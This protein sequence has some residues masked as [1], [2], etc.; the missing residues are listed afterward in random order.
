MSKVVTL[1]LSEKEYKTISAAAEI[2]HRPISNFITTM[3]LQEIEK[4]YYVDPIEMAQ[5]KSDKRLSEKLKTGHID[6]QKRRGRL[7]G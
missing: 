5:I 6:A 4:S 2:E 1:R 7:V 3:V